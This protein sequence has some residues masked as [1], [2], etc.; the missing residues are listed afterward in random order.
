MGRGREK[1]STKA[2]R[3]GY[4]VLH[5]L[6]DVLRHLLYKK[7]DD[8]WYTKE[9]DQT[10][11]GWREYMVRHIPEF[12]RGGPDKAIGKRRKAKKNDRR[13]TIR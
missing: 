8:W 2:R 6:T 9:Q 1:P 13:N 5:N 12:K 7:E 3:D 11:P 4:R 10:Y